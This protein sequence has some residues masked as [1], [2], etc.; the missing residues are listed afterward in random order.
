M[1]IQFIQL[2][3]IIPSSLCIY[4]SKEYMIP[5]LFSIYKH[6]NFVTIRI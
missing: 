6:Y 1:K 4:N 5:T 3:F 2:L